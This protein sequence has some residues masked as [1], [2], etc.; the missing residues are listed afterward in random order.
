L[1]LA[2]YFAGAVVF[3]MLDCPILAGILAGLAAWTKDEGVLFLALFV[4]TTALFKRRSLPGVLAGAL[5]AVVLV[6]FFKLSLARGN[7]SWLAASLPGAAARFHDASRYRTILS[8]YGREFIEMITAGYHPLYPLV[9]LALCLRF[10]SRRWRDAAFCGALFLAMLV[11]YL[12]VYVITVNDLRWHLATSL[13]RL[14]V[15]LWPLLVLAGFISLRTPKR[16]NR[17][18]AGIADIL[19]K[20]WT[21]LAGRLRHFRAGQP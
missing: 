18:L 20:P 13:D 7:P 15:Q 4:I 11:G 12:G 5:P 9:A 21:H 16:T 14:L 17:Q 6:A 1:P 19:P 2:C 8:A 10:D 3:G